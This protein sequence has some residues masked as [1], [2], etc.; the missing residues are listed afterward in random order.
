M[1]ELQNI[2]EDE[3]DLLDLLKVIIKNRKI[4]II[5]WVIVLILGISFGIYKKNTT[6]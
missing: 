4:I 6:Y 1:T 3:I 5:T 2:K